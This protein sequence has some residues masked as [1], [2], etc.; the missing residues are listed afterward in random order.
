M[1]K[2]AEL[3]RRQAGK[4]AMRNR[5]PSRPGA[6]QT[7]EP[8]GIGRQ[9]EKTQRAKGAIREGAKMTKLHLEKALDREDATQTRCHAANGTCRIGALTRCSASAVVHGAKRTAAPLHLSID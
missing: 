9:R 7:K 4:G 2:R 6:R 5:A 3:T 1:Q 8:C